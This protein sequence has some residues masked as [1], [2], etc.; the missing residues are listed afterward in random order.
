MMLHF[1]VDDEDEATVRFWLSLPKGTRS[2][3]FRRMTHWYGGE[4]GFASLLSALERLASTANTS[5]P[6]ESPPLDPAQPTFEDVWEQ[7][8]V[9][10]VLDDAIAQ[11]GL[12]DD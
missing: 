6:V 2:A 3:I 5:P 10:A 1:R 9:S 7:M 4:N 11:L 8:D 12:G